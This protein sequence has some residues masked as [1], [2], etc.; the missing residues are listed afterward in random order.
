MPFCNMELQILFFFGNEPLFIIVSYP[1]LWGKWVAAVLD[2]PHIKLAYS[3]SLPMI[4]LKLCKILYIPRMCF[5]E[6]SYF[7]LLLRMFS[8]DTA[9]IQIQFTLSILILYLLTLHHRVTRNLSKIDE[10]FLFLSWSP[11]WLIQKS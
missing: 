1:S 10:A 8:K 3:I 2:N 4:L 9:H 6:A 7:I 11:T 5:I